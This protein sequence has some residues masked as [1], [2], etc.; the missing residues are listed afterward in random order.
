MFTGIITEIGKLKNVVRKGS[1][2]ALQIACKNTGEGLKLGDSVAINGACLS[3]VDASKGALSFDVVENT[4]QKTNLKR[5]TS[6]DSVNMENALRMGEALSGHMVSGH[7]DGERKIKNIQKNAKECF[8][9]VEMLPGDEKHIVPKG[10]VA[11][12]G[13]SLTVGE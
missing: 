11:L 4:W 3:I 8:L 12:D 10:S 6:G 7:I 9:D 13:V 5:L 2:H 1:S